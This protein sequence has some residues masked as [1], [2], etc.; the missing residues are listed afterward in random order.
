MKA[1]GVMSV[2]VQ[3]WCTT[4]IFRDAL[5]GPSCGVSSVVHWQVSG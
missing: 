2:W 5:H 3:V 1:S 4:V